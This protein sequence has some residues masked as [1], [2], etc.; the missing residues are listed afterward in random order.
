MCIDPRANE[1]VQKEEI[2]RFETHVI[3]RCA[4]MKWGT[5]VVAMTRVFYRQQST[6]F[7]S[8]AELHFFQDS[9]EKNEIYAVFIL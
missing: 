2:K 6:A 7:R 3:F 9:G 8:F 5:H 1:K 4:T